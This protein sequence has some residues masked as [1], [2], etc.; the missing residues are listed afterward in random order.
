VLF[1]IKIN[2]F[3]DFDED[4]VSTFTA[5]FS[6]QA[7]NVVNKARIIINEKYSHFYYCQQ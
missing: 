2:L 7:V 3:E 4:S 1:T 5:E 6:E